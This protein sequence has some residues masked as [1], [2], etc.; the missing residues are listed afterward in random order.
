MLCDA[1]VGRNYISYSKTFIFLSF[2]L[3]FVVIT[4]EFIYFALFSLTL[5]LFVYCFISRMKLL[6]WLLI[7]YR[8]PS[9]WWMYIVHTY[10]R[11]LCQDRGKANAKA[12]LVRSTDT[13]P[14]TRN[15]LGPD[16][17]YSECVK[18]GLIN[19]RENYL[20]QFMPVDCHLCMS[21]GFCKTQLQ[22]EV[23]FSDAQKGIASE[24]MF[25]IFTCL[26]LG[27]FRCALAVRIHSKTYQRDM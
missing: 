20:I 23:D 10:V 22:F 11:A 4:C 25:H 24:R 16:E 3:I 21:Y 5:L 9:V 1:I 19:I 12:I 7:T 15:M 2:R 26:F 13:H 8:I 14:H 18:N 6:Y 27:I 17:N